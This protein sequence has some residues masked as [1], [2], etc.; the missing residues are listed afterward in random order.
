MRAR[1]SQLAAAH[2][3]DDL[4]AAAQLLCLVRHHLQVPVVRRRPPLLPRIGP[5]A[6]SVAAVPLELH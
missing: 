4:V 3:G 5:G 1:E 6:R 2:L